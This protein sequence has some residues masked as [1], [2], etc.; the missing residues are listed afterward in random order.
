MRKEINTSKVLIAAATY[1]KYAF[2]S[3]EALNQWLSKGG[4]WLVSSGKC[5]GTVIAIVGEVYNYTAPLFANPDG[6][7]KTE[8][9]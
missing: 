7:T 9:M 5:E 4:R 3:E 1:R 8:E 6:F 2:E